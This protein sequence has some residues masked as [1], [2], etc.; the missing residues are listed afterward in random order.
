MLQKLKK[1]SPAPNLQFSSENETPYLIDLRDVIKNYHTAAGDFTALRNINL[2]VS[3]HEFVAVIGKSG[4][5]KSTLINMVTGIDRPTYGEVFVDGTPIHLLNEDQMAIWRGRNLGVIFQ[6][7][8][9]LPTLTVIE[10]L[11]LPMEFCEMYTLQERVE[12]AM[13]LLELVEL[14]DQAYKLPSALSGGQQQRAAIA[15][16]LANDPKLLVADEPTGSLD[17]KTSDTVFQLFDDLVQQGKTILMVTH[18]RDLA[19]RVTRVVHIADGE[20]VDEQISQALP[21]LSKDQ[22]VRVASQLEPI[23]YPAGSVIIQEGDPADKFYIILKGQADVLVRHASAG[24][25]LVARLE[26]GQYFGEMGLVEGGQRTSTVRAAADSDI[27]VMALDRETFSSLLRDSQLTSA[28][29]ATLMRQ[30]ITEQHLHRI[31]PDL[32]ENQIEMVQA[33]LEILTYEPGAEIIRQGE[34]AE[35]FYM[36]L[37]GTVDV[38]SC[39]PTGEEE[40]VAQLGSGQYFGEIGLL[41]GGK[42]S[43]TVRAVQDSDTGVEVAA[44][45]RRAFQLMTESQLT[46]DEIAHMMRRRLAEKVG[47]FVP[48]LRRRPRRSD[49]LAKLNFDD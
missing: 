30:R 28:D 34:A 49:V 3:D 18:D 10:N 17:S 38:V 12:R 40:V 5:G 15:R 39:P 29:I 13:Y 25:V 47:D 42:R 46:K 16:A 24:D 20:I 32:T 21:S 23:V 6:F 36:M 4:S 37:K 41:R 14:A 31:V 27:S 44:M 35:K 7:F 9:L 26:S 22:L 8:Q 19:S 11:V 43:H 2:Q 1:R 48:D 33:D 45:G